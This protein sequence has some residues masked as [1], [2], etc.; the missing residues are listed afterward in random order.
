MPQL[1]QEQHLLV[2]LKKVNKF[3]FHIYKLDPMRRYSLD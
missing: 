3:V 2:K 1:W